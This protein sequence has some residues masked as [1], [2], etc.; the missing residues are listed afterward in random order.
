MVEI[1][2]CKTKKQMKLFADFPI[3]LYEGVE[4]FV[5]SVFEDEIKILSPKKNLMMGSSEARAFLAY[6]D[7][8]LVGRICAIINHESNKKH[9]EKCITF[10]RFDFVDDLEVSKALIM[11]VVEWGKE[12]GLEE[13]HGPWGF[14]DTDREG[15]LTMGFDE[16]SCYAT[17]YS[18]EYYVKHM[19]ALGF[20]KE[21]EWLEYRV[22][23][24]RY[25]ERY[26]KLAKML[27]ARGYKDVTKGRSIKWV[28]KHYGDK[29][30]DC[31]NQAYADL[32]NFIPLEGVAKK[33]TLK[34]FAT[35]I[36]IDYFSLIVD[37]DDEVAAFCVGLPYIGDALRKGKGRTLRSALGILKAIKKPWMIELALMGV[38][39]KYRNLG[40][41]ACAVQKFIDSSSRDGIKE[42]WF[43]PTLTTNAK[44]INSFSIMERELRAKRQ[45]YRLPLSKF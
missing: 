19:A 43:D 14:N 44:M 24:E 39:P 26:P 13:I 34:Q 8:K 25:D 41:H 17:A 1:V 45:T 37:K 10:S 15:M 6:K 16:K 5:P 18:Y 7:D 30:F 32:D 33:Q 29:F 38:N 28:V 31:Y 35:I 21:S 20:E 23:T 9:N 2:E 40:V 4:Q 11:K 42:M 27:E 12:R 36:N 22:Y 3:H